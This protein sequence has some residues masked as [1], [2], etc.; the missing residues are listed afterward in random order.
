[1]F[2]AE[3]RG[4]LPKG[5]SFDCAF[6]DVLLEP[7][8]LEPFLKVVFQGITAVRIMTVIF[9]IFTTSVPPSRV[10]RSHHVERLF[11]EWK[12]LDLGHN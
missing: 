6:P 12:M 9:V 3:G 4:L 2:I 1:M 10:R 7:T 8:I 5:D 11:E